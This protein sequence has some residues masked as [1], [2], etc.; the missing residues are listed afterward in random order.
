M[1]GI[2]FLTPK[3]YKLKSNHLP[4][5]LLPKS[6]ASLAGQE[7]VVKILVQNGAKVN[8]QSQV[9]STIR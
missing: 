7:E 6:P 1:N 2:L 8:A 4:A 5:S 9:R 3:S